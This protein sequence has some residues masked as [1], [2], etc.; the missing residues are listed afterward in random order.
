[1]KFILIIISSLLISAC[2]YT[3]STVNDPGMMTIRTGSILILNQSLT[4]PQGKAR[5]GV[6]YGKAVT[7]VNVNEPYCEF[8]INTIA[9]T[10]TTLPAGSY[11][12]TKNRG[13]QVPNAINYYLNMT[14]LSL[15]SSP[16]SGIS[17]VE[18]GIVFSGY[19]SR[20][21][22]IKEF[23]TLA[24]DVMTLQATGKQ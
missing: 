12:I 1:M 4:I 16:P 17:H 15:E 9:K 5:T 11:R 10:T 8:L 22:T 2:V 24:G 20:Y 18:C 14:V 19:E 21:L 7:G 6:Q 23:E 3:S 13:Y